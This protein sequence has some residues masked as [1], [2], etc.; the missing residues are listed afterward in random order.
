VRHHSGWTVVRVTMV[1]DHIECFID[2]KKY[3][4]V[5]D[6]TFTDAGMIGVWSKSDARSQFD[7]LTLD[8]E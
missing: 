7:D 1:D 6:S 3:L 8:G 5:A 2:G 4:D